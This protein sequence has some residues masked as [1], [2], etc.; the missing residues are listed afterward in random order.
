MRR[1]RKRKRRGEEKLKIGSCKPDAFSINI[2]CEPYLYGACVEFIS[3]DTDLSWDVM[4]QS[5]SKQ[6]GIEI[7]H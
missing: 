2:S 4:D 7:S 5:C 3:R 6:Q 1:G